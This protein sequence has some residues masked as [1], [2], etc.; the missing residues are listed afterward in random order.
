MKNENI[1]DILYVVILYMEINMNKIEPRIL[2]GFVEFLLDEQIA[3]NKMYDKIRSVYERFGFL[4]ID[5]PVLEYSDVLLA[6]AGG[7][8]EKQIYRFTKGDADVSMRFD[9]TVPLARYVAMHQN[10]LAFPFKRYHMAK[11]Y[12]GERPQKGRFRE[13]TQCDIDVIGSE[14]LPLIYDA[15]IPAVIYNVFRELDIG[16]FTVRINNRKILGGFFEYVGQSDNVTD[17][18]RIIDKLEKIGVEKVGEELGKIGVG[19]SAIQKILSFISIGGTCDE[20]ISSLRALGVENAT[21]SDGVDE[22]DEVISGIRSFGVPDEYF[23]VDLTIARGLD[24]YTGTVY[25]TKLDANPALG[26]ICSGGRYENLTGYYTDQ[27]LPGIGI[28]IGLTRLFSQLKDA[29]IVETAKKSIIDVLVIPMS[30]S[31]LGA[32]VEA[33][34]GFRRA[35]IPCDVYYLEKGMKPKMKYANR[36]GVPFTAIIGESERAE[37]KVALKN[38]LGDGQETVTVDQAIEIIKKA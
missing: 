17:I 28:S 38:M 29:G 8:T 20:I 19:D 36:I 24:Y 7:E 21:F 22:L 32:A 30:Q 16:K 3:Y 27:K 26:S 12:R 1:S 13:F 11:V 37:G 5:T 34:A 2:Q 6:K 4:P 31:E 15:E 33:A 10:D 14:T 35:G 23:T 25:E 18:M 9:L